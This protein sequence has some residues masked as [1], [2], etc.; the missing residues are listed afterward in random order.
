M[1]ESPA[2]LP[3]GFANGRLQGTGHVCLIY[4]S[5]EERKRLVSQY[6]AAGLEH[7]DLVR[8]FTDVT[9]ADEIRSWL[10]ELGVVVPEAEGSGQLTIANAASAYCSN[11]P[12]E[13]RAMIERTLGAY[14]SAAAAGYS[15]VRSTGEMTWVFRGLPGSDRWLEYEALLNTVTT[16]FPRVGMCQYDAR[17]FDGAA[18]F[19][20]LQVHPYLVAHGQLVRNPYYTRPAEFMAALDGARPTRVT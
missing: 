3:M 1:S 2:E 5:D 15:A 4:E 13:P 19:K 10:A 9:S 6:L 11:G 20:V 18:L 17:R 7:G 8:Y 14:D 12:F 16:S